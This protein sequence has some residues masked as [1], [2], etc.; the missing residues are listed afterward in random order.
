[1]N[2]KVIQFTSARGPNECTYVVYKIFHRFLK[3]IENTGI[4]YSILYKKEGRYKE[5]LRSVV[6]KL[7]GNNIDLVDEWIGIIQWIG[8]SPYRRHHKRKNWFVGC[9]QIE[10][11]ISNIEVKES[12]IRYQSIRSSGPGGQHVNKVSSAVRATHEKSGTTVLVMDN[13]SQHQNRK[14]A[15]ERIRE[16]IWNA[17]MEFLN[18]QKGKKWENHLNLERGNPIK[19]FKGEKF[20]IK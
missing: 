15:V 2:T 9:F 14:V 3:T 16:K 20:K 10:D 6:I 12:D 19:V 18:E 4:E 17:Y 7:Q 5:T 8:E 11:E 1:M 13:R